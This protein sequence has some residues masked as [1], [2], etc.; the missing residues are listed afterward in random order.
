[1]SGTYRLKKTGFTLLASLMMTTAPFLFSG[2]AFAQVD[3]FN[4]PVS[5]VE[6]NSSVLQQL[7]P[8]AGDTKSLTPIQLTPPIVTRKATSS[9]S[10]LLTE[11][12][13]LDP[14]GEKDVAIVETPGGGTIAK[15]FKPASQDIVDL[16]KTIIANEPIAP[17]ITTSAALKINQTIA[18]AN[19]PGSVSS[20]PVDLADDNRPAQI[21]PKIIESSAPEFADT[22]VKPIL[23]IAQQPAATTPEQ[24]IVPKITETPAPQVAK[25]EPQTILRTTP[26]VV[27]D[28]EKPVIEEPIVQVLAPAQPVAKQKP[29][30]IIT[31]EAPVAPTPKALVKEIPKPDNNIVTQVV[32]DVPGVT[33]PSTPLNPVPKT[34]TAAKPIIIAPIKSAEREEKALTTPPKVMAENQAVKA[35]TTKPVSFPITSNSKTRGEIDPSPL[36]EAKTPA[37]ISQPVAKKPQLRA[38]AKADPQDDF[39]PVTTLSTLTKNDVPELIYRNVPTPK[40]RPNVIVA[41]KEFVERARRTYEDTYTVV[42][43]DGD[44]MPAVH[45]QKV[46]RESLSPARISVADIARDP[47]ASKLVAMT[48]DD[49]ASALN[50]I[51]PAAGGNNSRTTEVEEVRT[52]QRIRIVRE[53]GNW[54]SRKPVEP[55][56]QTA[57]LNDLGN[58]PI[59]KPSPDGHYNITFKTGATDLPSSSFG[60]V[61]SGVI[62][63]LKANSNSRVQIVAYASAEDGK[64][65]TAKRTSLARALSLRSYLISKGIDATR[66]DVRAMGVQQDAKAAQDQVEMILLPVDARKS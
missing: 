15:P 18:P 32:M 55:R 26:A 39:A 42:K 2:P 64:D 57:S 21:L 13:Q 53:N 65:T 7:D 4:N 36:V 19:K 40:P 51:G 52:N 5:E 17:I 6:V 31:A 12:S 27:A 20:K 56:Q 48:P 59:A 66:M 38:L 10:P 44:S 62:S 16:A 30:P 22:A 45:T 43:R 34:V 9:S 61:D 60:E 23:K 46:A 54:K 50:D 1:M 49:I 14:S 63:A 24:P 35:A 37:I 47:L 8:S 41:S 33:I 28:L 29:A 11:V 58:E 3:N 25:I